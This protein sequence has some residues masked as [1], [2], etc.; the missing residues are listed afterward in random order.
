MQIKGVAKIKRN[1]QKQAEGPLGLRA[2]LPTSA[3]D[4]SSSQCNMLNRWECSLTSQKISV[5]VP[6][7][8]VPHLTVISRHREQAS[9]K[10]VQPKKVSNLFTGIEFLDSVKKKKNQVRTL[11]VKDSPYLSSY[12]IYSSH[13]IMCDPW[14]NKWLSTLHLE[15]VEC[16]CLDGHGFRRPIWCPIF[17]RVLC[18]NAFIKGKQAVHWNIFCRLGTICRSDS[19]NSLPVLFQRG[20]WVYR[21][22]SV[23][24]CF[25]LKKSAGKGL[26][27]QSQIS[28]WEQFLS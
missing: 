13:L 17:Y 12:R 27:V 3:L 21:G 6:F 9:N 18:Q 26:T 28:F 1:L 24:H 22:S 2:S 20:G 11:N 25:M 19:Q 14:T 7:L 4:P 8:S 5:S 10:V 16:V 15:R 23:F